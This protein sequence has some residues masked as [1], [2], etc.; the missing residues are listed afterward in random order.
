MAPITDEKVSRNEKTDSKVI[1]DD[2]F[3]IAI[4]K[5]PG[6]DEDD[7]DNCDLPNKGSLGEE[8]GFN[9]LKFDLDYED[10]GV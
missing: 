7:D 10:S 9:S 1:E 2:H 3:S 8:T 4:F 6:L 5:Q